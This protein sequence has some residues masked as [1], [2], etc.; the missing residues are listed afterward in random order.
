MAHQVTVFQVYPLQEGQKINIS[1]GPR[2]GDWLVIGLSERK[3]QLRCPV[4]GREV[5]WERFCYL[6]E[7]REQDKWPSQGE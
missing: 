6:V 3:M 5:E 2:R 7:E 1:A 4:S